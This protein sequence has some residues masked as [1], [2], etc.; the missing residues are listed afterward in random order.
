MLVMKLK[1]QK[2][3]QRKNVIVVAVSEYSFKKA[4]ME[5][6]YAFPKSCARKLKEYIAFYR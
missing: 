4:L 6:I 5:R 3:D 2:G 1:K